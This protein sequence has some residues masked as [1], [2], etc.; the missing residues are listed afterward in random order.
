MRG[1]SIAEKRRG[2]GGRDKNADETHGK[3]AVKE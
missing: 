1:R 2:E 3:Y